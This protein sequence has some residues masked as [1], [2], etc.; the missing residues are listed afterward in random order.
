MGDGGVFLT[1]CA[2]FSRSVEELPWVCL[3]WKMYR[4]GVAYVKY[5][6]D[7]NISKTSFS[8]SW[9]HTRSVGCL[10]EIWTG[11][12]CFFSQMS[13]SSQSE[14]L[15]ETSHPSQWPLCT[16]TG[17][18]F[19][20]NGNSRITR[21]NTSICTD[22]VVSSRVPSFISSLSED[23]SQQCIFKKK[24]IPLHDRGRGL[25]VVE[26]SLRDVFNDV[27]K[28]IRK[29]SVSLNRLFP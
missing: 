11:D 25:D 7:P 29:I 17:D 6:M 2:D 28:Y 24:K 18:S 21:L 23:F 13:Y 9:N 20:T 12:S 3:L 22:T 19:V 1:P 14:H 8:I 5:H 26:Q 10:M 16:R 15:R 4:W 27:S